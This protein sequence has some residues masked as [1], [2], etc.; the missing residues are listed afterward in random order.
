[1]IVSH[2][3]VM[4][5]GGGG[6]GSHETAIPPLGI[7]KVDPFHAV[8]PDASIGQMAGSSEVLPTPITLLE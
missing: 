5:G 3:H 4:G 2:A 7:I 6:D 8:Q 1:M